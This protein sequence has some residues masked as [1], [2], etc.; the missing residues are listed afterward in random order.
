MAVAINTLG[1][2]IILILFHQTLILYLALTLLWIFV[3][4]LFASWFPIPATLGVLVSAIGVF[5]FFHGTVGSTLDFFGDYLLNFLAAGFAVV[6]VHTLIWP[7][8]T[9]NIFAGATGECLFSTRG[10]TVP[11]CGPLA[12]VRWAACDDPL[13][14]L[15][16]LS[17]LRQ[18]LAPDLLR[19]RHT[20]N[21]FARMILACRSLILRLWFLN[22]ACAI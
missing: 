20:A 4:L 3:C 17:P 12:S 5:T 21:P 16:S 6:T 22:R 8:N 14:R 9:P 10:S 11:E 1:S 15:G 13:G 18:L 19:N 2:V 7:L